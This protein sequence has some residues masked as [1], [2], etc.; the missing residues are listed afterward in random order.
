MLACHNIEF[1]DSIFAACQDDVVDAF[2]ICGDTDRELCV[3]RSE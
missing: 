2:D 3:Y 1:G